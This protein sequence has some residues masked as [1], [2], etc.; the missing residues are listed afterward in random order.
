MC[1]STDFEYQEERRAAREW[2]VQAMERIRQDS[3]RSADTH[4]IK[5]D[6]KPAAEAGVHLYLK[7]ESVH[8][9]GS[10]K[11]RLARSLFIYALVNAKIGPN[12]TIVEASSGSTAVSEAYFA[13]MLGLRFVAVMVKGTS[14]AK[15]QLIE[16]QGGECHF[17]DDPCAIYAEAQR[18]ADEEG[19]YFMNQFENAEK[20][21]DW[22]AT[23][24]IAESI[25]KQMEREEHP[26]PEWVVVGAGTGGTSATIGRYL[27]YS[28]NS[29]TR[30][31]VA[32]PE[33][34][35]FYD[36][37]ASGG[38][39]SITS[40]KGSR[41]EGIG[42]PRVED[43]FLP[44]LV[45]HMIRV[46]DSASLASQ[47]FIGDIVGRR[48]GATTGTSIY[49]AFQLANEMILG[50]QKGSIVALICDSGERYTNTYY[51]DDWVREQ[52]FVLDPYK[53]QIG[54]FFYTLDWQEIHNP[55]IN[56]MYKGYFI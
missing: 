27:R 48:V 44:D 49:A 45:D 11:H 54:S 43:S 18:I 41:I 24:N 12:T 53:E 40:S 30:L 29:T 21:T 1:G 36:C 5:V 51:S 9:T 34:S 6:W 28:D 17:V 25:F 2:G 15:C 23:N 14:R 52:G 8:P 47:R 20:A 32:D 35:V 7:D 16:R 39:R 31:C 37:W 13:K 3:A 55:V 10:L 4:L 46:P 50:G 56:I 33:N 19:G 38:D 22:R 26:L 42:R